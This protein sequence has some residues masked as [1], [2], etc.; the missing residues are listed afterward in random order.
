MGLAEGCTV[1]RPLAKDAPLTYADVKLPAGRT[2]DRLRAE[3][4]AHFA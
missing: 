3:Q 1:L 4:N 2:A